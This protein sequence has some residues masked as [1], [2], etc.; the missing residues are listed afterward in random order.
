MTWVTAV[1]E[2]FVGAAC[3]AMGV[4]SWRRATPLFRVVAVVLVVAGAIAV[5]NA[6]ASLS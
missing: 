5:V 2:T 3:L 1:I 6:V 4:A